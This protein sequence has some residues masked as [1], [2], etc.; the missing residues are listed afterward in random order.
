MAYIIILYENW[1]Y[2]QYDSI[3]IKMLKPIKRKNIKGNILMC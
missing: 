1:R 3:N 2:K